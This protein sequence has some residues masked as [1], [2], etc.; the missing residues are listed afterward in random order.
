VAGTRQHEV[1][2][3]AEDDPRLSDEQAFAAATMC[4]MVSDTVDIL[5]SKG[6]R[7]VELKEFYLPVDNEPVVDG[8]SG[9]KWFGTTGGFADRVL[10]FDVQDEKTGTVIPGA[11]DAVVMDWK[12]G[13][14]AT[15]EAEHNLQGIAYALGVRKFLNDRGLKVRE[16]TVVFGSPHRNEDPSV[17]SFSSAALDEWYVKI[18]A[19]VRRAEFVTRKI[20]AFRDT[21][22]IGDPHL[23]ALLQP[24]AGTCIFCHN[25]GWCPA[26]QTMAAAAVKKMEPLLL[27]Q[28]LNGWDDVTPA[29]RA[30]GIRVAQVMGAWAT[31]YRKRITDDCL[32]HPERT[33]TGYKL[34][35][36]YPRKVVAPQ[37][38]WDYLVKRFGQ[39]TVIETI[40]MPLTP[41]EKIVQN[42]AERGNKAHEVEQFAEEL[43]SAKITIKSDI[44]VVSL[45]M[46]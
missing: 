16:V 15:V 36:S 4:K 13:R 39:K 10:Y 11:A 30:V 19:V 24:S 27:P 45:R 23:L 40:E 9:L 33:P 8:K 14:Y 44:P 29:G 28:D 7:P 38:L 26:I 18:V 3:S 32:E 46:T 5:K 43:A 21:D 12:F 17:Y 34:T 2:D 6:L 25:L 20:D 41:F 1:V 37:Q 42:A 31:K 22:W 35:D